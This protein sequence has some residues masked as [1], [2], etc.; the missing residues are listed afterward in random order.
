M[1]V[2]AYF[3]S[4]AAG[5][6]TN[7]SLNN[8][9]KNNGSMNSNNNNSFMNGNGNNNHS[10]SN[11]HMKGHND[12]GRNNMGGNTNNNAGNTNSN[13]SNIERFHMSHRGV[14]FFSVS[15]REAN[16]KIIEES[17][18]SGFYGNRLGE[19]TNLSSLVKEGTLIRRHVKLRVRV[20][21]I[22]HLRIRL[23]CARCSIEWT[24]GVKACISCRSTE[25]RV[26]YSFQVLV[27]DE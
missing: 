2:I 15:D 26:A 18:M 22:K 8:N 16:R 17:S 10:G 5:G 4:S 11:N 25:T 27:Q 1:F 20:K 19:F 12:S 23:N 24:Q 14:E 3:R 7:A 21:K 6:L 9:N 13:S